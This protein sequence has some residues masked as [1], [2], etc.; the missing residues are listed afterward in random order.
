MNLPF[1]LPQ[2]LV[3][4]LFSTRFNKQLHLWIFLLPQSLVCFP[5]CLTYSLTCEYSY[6]TATVSDLFS[7]RFNIQP[8]L[9]IFLLYCHSL[10][11]V[12]HPVY[13][14]T[15]LVNLPII[16][17][18]SLVCFPPSNNIQLQRAK[19]RIRFGGWDQGEHLEPG[20]D[21]NLVQWHKKASK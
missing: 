6:Y 12:F 10:W 21:D 11:S 17:P 8:H 2:S 1:I 15:S 18:Q 7:T 16:L 19:N 3:F 5:S 4:G 20:S 13:H 9:W 14:T